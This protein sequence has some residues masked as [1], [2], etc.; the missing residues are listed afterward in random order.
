MGSGDA[1]AA[2][3]FVCDLAAGITEDDLW[4][5]FRN[6]GDVVSIEQVSDDAAVVD[7]TQRQA[8]V[9]ARDILSYAS[10]RGKTCRCL[11]MDMVEVIRQTMVTGQRL[12]VEQLDPAVESAGLRDVCSLFGQ[13]LDCKV[14]SGE[15]AGGHRSGF[16]HFSSEGEAAKATSLMDGMQ[17]GS[18]VVEMRP[19]E[20]ADI[21]LFSGCRYPSSA[22]RA[23]APPAEGSDA[24]EGPEPNAAEDEQAPRS[25]STP[26]E[27]EQAV[28]ERFKSLEYHYVEH[29]QDVDSKLERLKTLLQ[30]YEPSHEMQI[31]VVADL[32]SLQAVAGLLAE[33]LQE[34]DFDTVASSSSK[35]E[36]KSI[37][38]GYEYGNL[39]V[40]VMSSEVCT[41]REFDLAK[42]SSVLINFDCAHTM[43]THIHRIFKRADSSTRVHNFFAPRD[44]GGIDVALLKALEESGYEIP[45]E[46]VALLITMDSEV[47]TAACD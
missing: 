29:M 8:A 1:Q 26:E 44:D 18:S 36:R 24:D 31:V 42:P 12:V 5:V 20:L 7:Y 25:S 6:Y 28:L 15:D 38:E 40:V 3:L 33:C 46:L 11:S 45:P 32:N 47:E 10:V 17:I 27:M 19:F 13:V 2:G 4:E 35:E 30:L 21:V 9:E 23:K 34:C 43:P 41:R 14:E 16:V 37:M 22:S 39:Y